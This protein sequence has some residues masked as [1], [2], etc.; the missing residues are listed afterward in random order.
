M[1]DDD[2]TDATL[3][4]TTAAKRGNI[5]FCPICGAEIG[6]RAVACPKC[7]FAHRKP[8]ADENVSRLWYLVPSLD[9]SVG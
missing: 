7:W 4:G 1:G 5:E 6:V 2:L 9:S 3:K 8:K